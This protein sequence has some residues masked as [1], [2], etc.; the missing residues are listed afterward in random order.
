VIR[1]AHGRIV[2]LAD[3]FIAGAP[4]KCFDRLPLLAGA[5]LVLADVGCGAR[6]QVRH[7]G[8]LDIFAIP[9]LIE[10]S[11]EFVEF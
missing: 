3:E 11:I 7:G 10:V 8:F 6:S 1:D 9:R 2:E 4:S 5:V